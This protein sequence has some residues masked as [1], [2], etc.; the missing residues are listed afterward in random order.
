MMAE[1]GSWAAFVFGE[2]SPRQLPERI[3][4]TIAERER[5]SEVLIGWAQLFLVV[6][7][8]SFYLVAPKTGDDLSFQ[9]VPWALGAYLLFT[10]VRLGLA[11]RGT[12]NAPFLI[13]SI[14]ADVVLLM[15]LI[16]SF[17]IQ[18]EQ[19]ASFY[20][21]A[22][23][24]LYVFIFIAL[25]ALRSDPRFVIAAG[26]AAMVGW[27]AMV[28]YVIYGD[29]LDAMITRDYV[30][31]MTSNH[32]LI[33]AEV[34][35]IISIG[36][37][38]LVLGIAVSRARRTLEQAVSEHEAT[39]NLSRFVASEIADRIISSEKAIE[40]GDGEARVATVMFT[41][42]EGFSTISENMDSVT[43]VKSL[44]DY[45]GALSEAISANGGTVLQFEG[46]A[47]LISFNTVA[48]DPN[49]AVHA[50]QTAL[51]IQDCCNRLRFGPN[52]TVMKTRCGINTGELTAGAVGSADRMIFTVHGDEVNIAARLEQLNK[53]YGTYIL[54]TEA[55]ATEIKDQIDT[56]HMGEVVVRGREKP[57][58]LFSLPTDTIIMEALADKQSA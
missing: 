8:G 46:D 56:M 55:T 57:T 28:L 36:M 25:R 2:T 14:I 42:I 31:Y 50:V 49:H 18:Y 13:G 40:P 44:N 6:T 27:L 39:Q 41:D 15:S 10:L 5:Q 22:P 16:W 26:L 53:Q 12:L 52:Q 51:G 24:L 47:M 38:T 35:K 33:G 21:K 11:H 43:L 34:D 4:V 20:L 3:R 54:M 19:P 48:D 58:Q 37:V 30:S 32:I 45:F 29:P 17:H 7:F 9:P 23:T 1:K